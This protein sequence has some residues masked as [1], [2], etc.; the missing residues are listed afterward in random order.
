MVGVGAD[1]EQ[2]G[3]GADRERDRARQR[4]RELR[5]GEPDDHAA[6]RERAELGAVARG[7][8]RRVGAAAQLV[9]DA[10]VDQRAQEHV[11]EPVRGAADEE[12]EQGERERR[13]DGGAE[14]A[15]ALGG[16]AASAPLTSQADGTSR[17]S[18]TAPPT[19]PSVH[20]VISTP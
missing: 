1:D 16:H 17:A 6:E 2:E 3:D 13:A 4:E 19:I 12:A 15:G 14:Q 5:A 9:G 10:L 7:V 18:P 20:A 8:V 11:L